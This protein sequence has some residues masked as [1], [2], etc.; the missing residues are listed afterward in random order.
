MVTQAGA[1]IRT[2]EFISIENLIS[3]FCTFYTAID[4]L[5]HRRSFLDLKTTISSL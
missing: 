3:A 4:E 1:A 2:I 5:K